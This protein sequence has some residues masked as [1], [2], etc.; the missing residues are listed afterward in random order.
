M[1]TTDRHRRGCR[2]DDEHRQGR[3]ADPNPGRPI[4]PGD[5]HLHLTNTSPA[6]TDPI[7]LTDLV[8]DMGTADT[9]DDAVLFDGDSTVDKGA[10]YVSGDD[11]DG[12]L[13]QGESWV[14]KFTTD[15]TLDAGET[16][17]NIVSV[18][19]HDDEDNEVGDTDDASIT[20]FNLGRTPGFWANLKNGGK[21][22][23]G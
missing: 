2:P 11:G 20:A 22:W 19:G 16:R 7:T 14:F 9:G 23:D 21:L 12:L 18:D 5:L 10:Y 4:D 8:D 13:E 6:S 17:T 3:V 1:T 15:V